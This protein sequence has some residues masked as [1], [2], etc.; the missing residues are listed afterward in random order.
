MPTS[1][2]PV[3]TV[4]QMINA[5]IA[6]SKAREDAEFNATV[7]QRRAQVNVVVELNGGPSIVHR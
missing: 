6:E 2:D 7:A 5:E 1:P 4:R 3:A